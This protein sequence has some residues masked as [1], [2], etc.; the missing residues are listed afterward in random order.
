M[1]KIENLGKPQ[2]ETNNLSKGHNP[3]ESSTPAE[4]TK[5]FSA[6]ASI[7]INH[8]KLSN[9]SNIPNLQAFHNK[10]M[11]NEED[12]EDEE[13]EDDESEEQS[14]NDED[15]GDGGKVDEAK[16]G[17]QNGNAMDYKFDVCNCN[18]SKL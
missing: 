7:Q 5:V 2:T 15:E 18:S 17:E 14:E 4:D 11:A 1:D 12:S 8:D 16:T 3:V 9:G 10:T 13:V 6:T